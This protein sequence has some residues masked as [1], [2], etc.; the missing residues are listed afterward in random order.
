MTDVSFDYDKATAV[1]VP[2]AALAGDP[3]GMGGR[4]RRGARRPP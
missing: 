3:A 1:V 4:G 2:G